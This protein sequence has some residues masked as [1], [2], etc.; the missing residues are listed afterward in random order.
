MSTC[1]E[2]GAPN[3]AGNRFC[4][5]CGV[6][7]LS[8]ERDTAQQSI[9]VPAGGTITGTTLAPAIGPDPAPAGPEAPVA[10][11]AP[12]ETPPAA[13][14]LQIA[15]DRA[16]RAVAA[17]KLDRAKLR[18]GLADA[19]LALGGQLLFVVMLS[20]VAAAFL[21]SGHRGG[22]GD[23]FATAVYVA[24]LALH[25]SLQVVGS[26]AAA[27]GNLIDAE[28]HV[29]LTASLSFMPLLFTATA[30]VAVW[31]VAQ[32]RQRIQ[33]SA[34]R[35]SACGSAVATSVAYVVVLILLASIVHSTGGYGF[36]PDAMSD[37]LAHVRVGL[38]IG[39]LI[40][41]PLL[42]TFATAGLTHELMR[43]SRA[44]GARVR[45]MIHAAAGRWGE[46]IE[47]AL[48]TLLGTA[49]AAAVLVL[50]AALTLHGSA[51]LPMTVGGTLLLLPN[52]ALVGASLAMGT[53]VTAH[54]NTE[55]QGYVYGL[56][57][58]KSGSGT[59]NL[60]LVGGHL[61]WFAWA[62]VLLPLAAV[63]VAAVR[64]TLTRPVTSALTWRVWGR[65]LVAFAAL[66]LAAWA[67]VGVHAGGRATGDLSLSSF[68]VSGGGDFHV[69]AG[70]TALSAVVAAVVWATIA[71]AIRRNIRAI[72]ATFPRSCAAL[73]QATAGR[74]EPLWA[75]LI[76]DAAQRTGLKTSASLASAAASAALPG[77]PLVRLRSPRVRART[78]GTGL[79]V[80]VVLCG[81]ALGARAVLAVTV[82]SPKAAVASYFSALEHGHASRALSL[83]GHPVGSSGVPDLLTDAALRVQQQAAPLHGVKISGVH[84]TGHYATADVTYLIGTTPHSQTVELVADPRHGHLL[85]LQNWHV[86]SLLA[87]VAVSAPASVSSV[88][89]DGVSVPIDPNTREAVVTVFPGAIPVA[90]DAQSSYYAVPPTIVVPRSV[91]RPPSKPCPT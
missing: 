9:A 79:A 20:A 86:E 89:L 63:V 75:V 21:P 48:M 53:G 1:P 65:Y 36:R 28:G 25:G 43:M 67:V 87:T 26:A 30:L 85:G 62:L 16:A 34:D 74:I 46:P 35:G 55:L 60:G 13:D 68:D 18:A 83:L 19:T 56:S 91:R 15:H 54:G 41:G 51:S 40:V 69:D 23:W 17:L 4:A 32:R 52:L 64:A 49:A 82:Y 3:A 84:T 72:I 78:I 6:H 29:G 33:P 77:V 31:W 57:G 37:E 81:G 2:C 10:G 59:S 8:R 76:I 71:L 24:G 38:S 80:L 11:R 70:F 90:A 7:L 47:A 45:A 44:R 73:V 50:L 14:A 58:E 22:I 27:G 12:D 5:G 66:S 61:P 39:S 42:L 88:E